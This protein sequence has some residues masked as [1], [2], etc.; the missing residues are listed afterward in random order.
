MKNE[1]RKRLDVV[2]IG[3]GISGIGSA[4]HLS[5]NFPD[6]TFSVLESHESFGGTWLLH[7]FPGIRSDSD[8]YTFG[9]RFKPWLGKP[10]ATRA[11]ILN[12]LG[13]TIEENNL[14]S[15]FLYNHKLLRAEWSS[16]EE[17]WELSVERTDTGEQLSMLCNFLWTCQGYYRHA[18]GY[19]PEWPGMSDFKGRIVHPQTWPEDLDVTGKR[20]ICIGSGATTA[21]IVPS[22]AGQCA[23]VTVL[24]RS[25]TYF[26]AGRN[27]T[28]KIDELRRQNLSDME[29]HT[30]MRAERM[31]FH[32]ETT[33]RSFED[34]EKLRGELL[35]ALRAHLPEDQIQKHFTPRYRPWQQRV[36]FVPDA[37]LFRAMTEGKASMVTDE[38]ER[39]T[40]RGIL[41]KSGETLEADVIVTAT[42]FNMSMMGDTP[43]FVDGRQV[44]WSKIPAYRSIMFPGVPNLFWTMGYFRGSWT[45]RVELVTDF[46]CNLLQHMEAIGATRVEARLRPEDEN[47]P[48]L[49]WIAESDFNPGYLLR[50]M[51][52]LPKRIDKPE[53][54]PN[55]HYTIEA[56][57][58]PKID[59]GAPEFVYDG[60]RNG[61]ASG[62]LRQDKVGVP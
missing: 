16:E 17:A 60:K 49:D 40:E 25:P 59:F 46:V 7:T 54:T 6:K 53:W 50:S 9:F 27:T 57:E 12:Y 41:L 3:A 48:L 13:E 28:D 47:L 14:G 35:Q 42:G 37:D 21:T 38:I 44:D 32:A 62:A 56:V 10:I 39:F 31:K 33:R 36:A 11:E 51:H 61:A 1:I 8:L 23:H 24:Q 4:Y 2:I 55:R 18:E 34:A 19:T 58:F 20:V 43:F 45:M 26:I 22:I 29:I 52:V 5:K 15:H 30:A